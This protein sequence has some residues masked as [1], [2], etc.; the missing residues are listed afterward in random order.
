MINGRY[1]INMIPTNYDNT[2]TEALKSLDPDRFLIQRWGDPRQYFNLIKGSIEGCTA[3]EIGA[4]LGRYTKLVIEYFNKIYTIESSTLCNTYLKKLD[5]VEPYLSTEFIKIPMVDFVYSFSTFL[6]FSQPEILWYFQQ[7]NKKLK[8]GKRF[9]LHYMDMLKG[10]DTLHKQ[11]IENFN[12]VGRYYFYSFQCMELMLRSRGFYNVRDIA[13][14]A[15]IVKGHAL[16][17]CEKE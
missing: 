5:D 12:D 3:L 10:Y 8:P 14:P 7:I 2:Y 4:G 1:A 17:V 9:V 16:I 15:P 11:K 13:I 6:H